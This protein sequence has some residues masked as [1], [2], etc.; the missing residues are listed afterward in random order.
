MKID[1]RVVYTKMVLKNSLL[2]LIPEKPVNK[3]TV[4][5]ICDRADI[6]RAT[7]YAHFRDVYDMLEQIENDLYETISL[8]LDKGW[9]TSSIIQLLT[10]VC[11]DI[12]QNRELCA[13][14]FSENGDRDF[15]DR[16][17]YVARDKCIDEWKSVYPEA[18]METFEKV[19]SFFSHGIAAVV[20]SWIQGGMTEAPAEIAAFIERITEQGLGLLR[21]NA[22]KVPVSPG[23]NRHRADDK[24]T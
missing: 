2:E 18:D 14:L 8:S 4:K 21:G 15:L 24:N 13:V 7:F 10:E 17:M 11:S 19:Y 12:K 22:G 20:M 6:N 1:R 16:I 23:R 5:E 3:I 9:R